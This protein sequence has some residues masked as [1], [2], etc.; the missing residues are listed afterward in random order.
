M[1]PSTGRP[2]PNQGLMPSFLDRLIDP[3]SG[4]TS[5]RRGYS[6]EQMIDAVRRDLEDLLNTR[7]SH[8]GLS[9]DFVEL[10]KSVLAFGLPDLMSLNAITPTQRED[11]GRTLEANIEAFEPRLK[12][13]RARLVDPGDGKER[14]VK[15]HIEARLNLDPAPEVAFD[16]VLELASGH[17]SVNQSS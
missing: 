3:D 11:I 12:D 16:T 2:D 10:Q 14:S 7:Q 9:E 1:P 6:V 4:G 13:I 17:Y 5:W 15:F 8:Q